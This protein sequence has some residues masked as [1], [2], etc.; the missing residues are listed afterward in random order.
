MREVIS[1]EKAENFFNE[2][3]IKGI[4]EYIVILDKD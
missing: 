4:E 3:G 2:T 1:L